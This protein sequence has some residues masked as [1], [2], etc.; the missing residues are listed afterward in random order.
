MQTS[1]NNKNDPAREC[2]MKEEAKRKEEKCDGK[3]QQK[4]KFKMK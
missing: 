4:V 2:E 1:D 3:K